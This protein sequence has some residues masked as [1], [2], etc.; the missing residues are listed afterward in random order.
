M[1]PRRGFDR[2]SES[3]P[4]NKPP[5][6]SLRA[7]TQPDE[8]EIYNPA[9]GI[10]DI[11][12]AHQVHEYSTA[13]RLPDGTVLIAGGQL[14]GGDGSTSVEVYDS[15]TGK[16]SNVADLIIGRHGHTATLLSDGTVLIA[17]G[18]NGWP[19]PTASGEIYKK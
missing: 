18:Y 12:S 19:T 5:A 3:A 1:I 13:T 10:T 17:G 14:A 15:A 7:P 9:S 11:G 2:R 4:A 8:A 16:F 6:D